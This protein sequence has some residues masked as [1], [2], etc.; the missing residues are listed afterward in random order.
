MAARLCS[1]KVD[2]E[3]DGDGANGVLRVIPGILWTSVLVMGVAH[4]A[5]PFPYDDYQVMVFPLLAVALSV[6][7]VGVC[8]RL[9]CRSITAMC[10]AL[11]VACLGAAGSSPVSQGWVMRGQDRLGVL[12]HERS[13]LSV[14]QEI[15]RYVLE[16]VDRGEEIL[17]QDVYLAVETGLR[18]PHGLEM[19]Q[20]SYFPDMSRADAEARGLLNGPMLRELLEGAEAELAAFSGYGLAVRCPEVTELSAAEQTELWG[21]VEGRYTPLKEVDVFGQAGT[22]LR[23]LRRKPG[24]DSPRSHRASEKRSAESSGRGL[25]HL[26]PP[27]VLREE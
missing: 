17:T 14:L 18:V 1:S 21:I 19:G 26:I 3:R 6:L 15:G 5:A 24:G 9:S 13:P 23:I 12:R 25:A 27:T 10:A 8:A 22:T 4:L 2:R 11:L 20:F 7:A 16:H